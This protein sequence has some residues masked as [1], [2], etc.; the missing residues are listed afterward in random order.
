MFVLSFK[1]TALY[2][3]LVFSISYI[4]CKN[5]EEQ[6]QNNS[7]NN[8]NEIIDSNQNLNEDVKFEQQ[9]YGIPLELSYNNQKGELL[10]DKF[11]PIG[12]SQDG[13]FAYI[14]EQA[15]EG[16]G[17]YWF[18]IIVTDIVNNKIVWSWKPAESEEGNLKSTWE[19]NYNLFAKNLN[20]SEIVQNTNFDL[21]PTN[22]KYKGNNYSINIDL[23]TVT[24]PDFGFEKIN[25]ISIKINS[26]ELG[27]K[28]IYNKK[29]DQYSRIIGAIIP[30]Y[31]LSNKDDR[32]L[33]IL[34]K[35]QVGYEGPP[36]VISYELINSNLTRG[37]N[38][39]DDI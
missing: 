36:N 28:Q 1:K 20:N 6:Q 16:S 14:I 2:I 9:S 25:K 21:K 7:N 27:E 30:G 38:K 15:D 33:V 17:Y 5:D 19:G 24:D 3:I 29:T 10:Y 4:S 23:A 11:Y 34:K 13:K 39:D 32:I 26:E 12:W 18:E 37:F 35:E 31:I 8:S 22:T